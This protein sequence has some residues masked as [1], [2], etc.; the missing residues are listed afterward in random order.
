MDR[1][2]LK[3][4]K[5]KNILAYIEFLESIQE[6]IT[7]NSRLRTYIALRQQVDSWNDQITIKE[8]VTMTVPG[9]EESVKVRPGF[10]DLFADKDTKDFDRVFKYITEADGIEDRLQK[11]FEKLTPKEQEDS[12]KILA[13][14]SAEKYIFKKDQ[15]A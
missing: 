12:Q 6:L 14:S 3:P 5:D 7:K 9:T 8:E 2:D 1:P 11:M 4:V 15:P 10:V 13:G